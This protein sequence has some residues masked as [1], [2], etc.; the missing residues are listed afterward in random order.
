MRQL[1][2]KRLR[3]YE[4]NTGDVRPSGKPVQG[5]RQG[6]R[7]YRASHVTDLIVPRT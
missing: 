5:D 2:G 6:N 1:P 3:Q 4:G 7:V